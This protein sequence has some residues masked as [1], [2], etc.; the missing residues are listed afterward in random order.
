VTPPCSRSSVDCSPVQLL[1]CSRPEAVRLGAWGLRRGGGRSGVR[2]KSADHRSAGGTVE[3]E[4]GHCPQMAR[5]RFKDR[6]QH[7]RAVPEGPFERSPARECWDR[8]SVEPFLEFRRN[9]RSSSTRVAGGRG[10]HDSIVPTGLPDG[11]CGLS[12]HF[13]AGLRSAV[14]L[15]R[16]GGARRPGNWNSPSAGVCCWPPNEKGVGEADRR[17]AGLGVNAPRRR[18]PAQG[19]GRGCG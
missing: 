9:D 7:C 5:K 6:R 16:G 1:H 17:Q 3:L 19:A 11:S 18:S 2:S 12:Q 8:S 10:L 13:R 14:P 4:K 15:G